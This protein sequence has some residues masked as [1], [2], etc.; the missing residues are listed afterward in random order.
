LG[1]RFSAF[2]WN[3]DT[4]TEKAECEYVMKEWI[5]LSAGVSTT[6]TGHQCWVQHEQLPPVFAGQKMRIM[7]VSLSKLYYDRRSVG[8]SV[9]MSSTH[10]RPK[11][12][13]LLLS[14][15]CG[16]VHAGRPL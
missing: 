15:S 1:Q 3:V 8:Q 13:F 11:I 4:N 12:R 5:Q 7:F 2:H 6:A 16:F 10:L 9:L 14:D